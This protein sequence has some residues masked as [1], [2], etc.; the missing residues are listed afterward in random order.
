[1]FPLCHINLSNVVAHSGIRNLKV[2]EKNLTRKIHRVRIFNSILEMDN[3]GISDL[4]NHSTGIQ[5][6]IHIHHRQ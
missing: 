1:M 5:D 6:F 3:L 2:H 4:S